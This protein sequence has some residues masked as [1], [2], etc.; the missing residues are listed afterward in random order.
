MANDRKKR[1]EEIRKRREFIK[2]NRNRRTNSS[3]PWFYISAFVMKLD[4]GKWVWVLDGVYD[5]YLEADNEARKSVK[6]SD[7]EHYTIKQYTTPTMAEATQ[8]WKKERQMIEGL[9]L[10]EA[11]SNIRHQGK[12]INFGCNE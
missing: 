8:I 6:T 10:G 1:I 9:S 5:S 4:S 7:G 12:D 11:I 2:G 3:G